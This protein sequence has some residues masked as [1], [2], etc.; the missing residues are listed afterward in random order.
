MK[1]K[2]LVSLALVSFLSVGSYADTNK[3]EV[4]ALG[5]VEYT[6]NDL[7]LESSLKGFGIRGN[8]RIDDNWLAGL[9]YQRFSGAD[10]EKSSKDDTDINRYFL[11]A[12]YQFNI[13]KSYTPYIIA[14]LGYQDVKDEID[15]FESGTIAQVG[16]GWK[17]KITEYLNFLIEGKYIRDFE[18]S[19][20]NFAISAGLSIPF[21]YE[22]KEAPKPKP[23]KTE[24][25][26]D[27]DNDGVPDV[28]DKCPDTP[29]GLIVDPDGCP[30]DSDGD[31]V[32][33]YL[34][35]CPNTPSGVKVDKNGCCLD[36]D[37]DG[38]P[39][40]KDKCPNTP[41]GFQVDKNGCPAIFNFKINFDFDSAK[42]KPQYFKKIK[43]FADFLKR[44]KKYKAEIQGHTDSKGSFEY[45]LKL[46]QKRAKAVYDELIKLGIEKDRLSY[47]GYGETMPIADN[48]TEEGRAQNRRVE[49]HLYY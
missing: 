8:Y 11:N 14:G 39:D 41:E 19:A 15:E 24:A 25:P 1:K 28:D 4:E 46:S 43:E 31:G 38:V 17:T 27:S 7:D 18:N 33:D 3:Y 9:G 40:Y 35:K 48:S 42:I 32:Y 6:D 49:A 34:D 26:K 21:G 47:K 30:P 16:I 44:N 29:E 37:N 23:I 45:N 20:N 22:T 13:N 2:I 36:S 5:N 12:F 10:Y